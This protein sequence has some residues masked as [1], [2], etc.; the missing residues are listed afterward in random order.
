MKKVFFA[1]AVLL[2]F[3]AS[4]S[5]DEGN[6]VTPEPTPEPTPMPVQAKP[7]DIKKAKASIL[8]FLEKN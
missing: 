1:I 4:C 6:E 5:K 3:L 7:D 2:V 8:N